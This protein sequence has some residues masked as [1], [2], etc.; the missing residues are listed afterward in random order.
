MD[1]RT[2]RLAQVMGHEGPRL[3]LRPPAGGREWEAEPGAVRLA[4][5]VELLIAK[6]RQANSA[7]RWGK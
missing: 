2:D 3:Q 7:S 6:V 5:D 1:L 4:T